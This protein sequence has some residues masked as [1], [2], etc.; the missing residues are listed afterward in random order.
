MRKPFYRIT[1]EIVGGFLGS[2]P[3]YRD[4]AWFACASQRLFRPASHYVVTEF[5]TQ[6]SI[7]NIPYAT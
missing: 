1:P 5:E 6:I 3:L 2:G 7:T 4:R